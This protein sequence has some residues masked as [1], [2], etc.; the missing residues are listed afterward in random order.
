[1]MEKIPA[2][3]NLYDDKGRVHDVEAAQEMAK[4]EQCYRSV[5]EDRLFRP[6]RKE[7]A[8]RGADVEFVGQ[9]ALVE[10]R[11]KL[12]AQQAWELRQ[13]TERARHREFINRNLQQNSL[14]MEAWL[15]LPADERKRLERGWMR[16]EQ[17][18][19]EWMLEQRLNSL[20]GRKI[21][22]FNVGNFGEVELNFDEGFVLSFQSWNL[23]DDAPDYDGVQVRRAVSKDRSN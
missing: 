6:G 10:K 18:S 21:Y 5:D 1:M 15:S 7:L 3:D 19:P 16:A 4:A 23:H 22:S 12:G 11:A 17:Q 13:E 14:S 9:K 2:P 8:K 20:I